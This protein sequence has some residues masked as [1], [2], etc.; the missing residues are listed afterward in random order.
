MSPEWKY[1]VMLEK[2]WHRVI[3]LVISES[4]LVSEVVTSAGKASQTVSDGLP[5]AARAKALFMLRLEK[6]RA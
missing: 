4:P 5:L 3:S 2:I 6:T 1:K